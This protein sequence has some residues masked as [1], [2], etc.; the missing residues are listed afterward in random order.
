[1][2]I[3]LITDTHWGTHG[4]SPVYHDFFDKFYSETFFP[5]LKENNIKTI[6]HLGDIVDRRKYISFVTAKRLYDDFIKKCGDNNIDLHVIVGNHDTVFKNT[7]DYN[8]M[9][10]LYG[11]NIV[12]MFHWYEETTEIELGELKMLFVPWINSGNM[13]QS[14][15]RIKN[16]KAEILFGHLEIK[17]FEMYRGSINDHGFE[18][19]IFDK[20]DMVM[21]GHFHHK[22]SSRNIHYLGA[23]YEMTWSDYNDDRGFHIFDTETRELEYVLNPHKIFNKVFYDDALKSQ[24][25]ILNEDY[26]Y[27]KDTNVKIIVRSKENPY[28]FDLFIDKI[29]KYEPIKLQVVDD[30]FHLDL[31]DTDD[32]IDEAEDTFSILRNFIKSLDIKE[33]KQLETLFHELYSDALEVD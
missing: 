33:E 21:S 20:F 24:N 23:P 3:A 8:S 1:M 7:N 30:N 18:L 29:N 32:I 2:K 17:G 13:E 9:K 4:D 10:I 6:I 22:S 25:D 12:D 5:Y 31:E 16:T 26:S 19:D 27:V 14:L 15:E 11:H 28:L